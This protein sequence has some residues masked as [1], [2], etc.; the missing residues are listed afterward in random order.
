MTLARSNVTVVPLLLLLVL[1]LQLSGCQPSFTS[2]QVNI[3]ASNLGIINQFE[4]SR[5]HNRQIQASS[6]ISV[7]SDNIEAVDSQALSEVVGRYLRPYFSNVGAGEV[8]GSLLEAMKVAKSQG[9]NYLVYIELEQQNTL[10]DVKKADASTAY[11]S[12]LISLTL[13]DVVANQILDK[14]RLQTK[15]SFYNISGSDIDAL[16]AKPINH[17]AKNLRGV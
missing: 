15:S 5:W 14:I 17:I 6:R 7:I 9:N 13:V 8:K 3:Y 11:N 16:L 2:Q 4:I 1:A 12:L 10:F